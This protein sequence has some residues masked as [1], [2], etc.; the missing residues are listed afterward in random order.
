MKSAKEIATRAIILLCLSNRCA[1]EKRIIDGINYTL[2]E[3]E[4]QREA[5]YE[6]LIDKGYST[7]LTLEEKML[8]GQEVGK[9][10]ID[11][12]LSKQVQY[13]A[14]EPCLWSLGLTDILSSYD[15]YVLEDFHPVLDIGRHHSLE[16]LL[17]RCH[18]RGI[19]N[20]DLEKEIS[21]LWHW[22]T[23][24]SDALVFNHKP[25]KEVILSTFGEKYLKALDKMQLINDKHNDFLVNKK[26]YGRLNLE[27]KKRTELIAYWRHYAFE[28]IVGEE[29]WENIELNT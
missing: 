25:V 6:W 29:D 10:D 28:W 22:R 13:E 1:L 2:N 23:R 4:Q 9:G 26:E 15:S 8:F 19:D 20:I 12:V 16:N 3:R 5:I 18:L 21:M 24:E 27:E 14:I 17:T 7:S 11:E